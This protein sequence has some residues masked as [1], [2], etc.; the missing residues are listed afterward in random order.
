MLTLVRQ[1]LRDV[2]ETRS[3]INRLDRLCAVN[4]PARP[5]WLAER[6]LCREQLRACL[7][8]AESLGI[9]ITPGV[10]CEA[11]FPFQHQWV[12]PQGDNKLRPAYFVYSDAQTTIT[13]WFFSGW[14][15]DRRK[16]NPRWW[17]QFRSR[18]TARRGKNTRSKS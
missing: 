11:L 9:E 13:E 1:I 15:N 5:E 16:V 8:E 2:R 6:A 10:R 7:V 17:R 4:K 3:R 14:P 18:S 12:G